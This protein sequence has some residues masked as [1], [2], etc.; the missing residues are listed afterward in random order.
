MKYIELKQ[1]LKSRLENAY[2]ITGDDRYLCFDALKKIES[3]VAIQIKD[4]N[5][6]VISGESTTAKD[7]VESANVY[8]FGDQYRLVLVKNFA[9]TKSKEE[10]KVI[11]NYLKQ[12]LQ[13]TILIFF[14][15]D[16][17]D[18]FKGMEGLTLVDCSKI[19][20]KVISA[21]IKNELAKNQIASSDSAI[22]TL[23]LYCNN[24]MSKVTNE[25]EKL[26]CYVCDSKVLTEEIVK[27]FVTQEKEFQVYKLSEFLAKGDAKEAI[28]LVDSFETKSSSSFQIITTLYNNYRRALF[29]SLAKDK[30]NAE[31]ATLL[32]VKEFAIKMLKNQI[33]VFNS[34]QLKKIVDMIA[35]FDKKIKIGEIKEDIAIKTIIFNILEIRGHNGL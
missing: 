9:P 4:M 17:T 12:P 25:L 16:E 13:S 23:I 14:N 24:D 27:D 6:V 28:D 26:I 1:N 10:S 2:L 32:G 8:P 15:P 18:F 11:S 21:F 35:I 5:Y 19:N 31:I 33:E 30:T 22:D 20:S 34:K 3:A 29:A 7:I